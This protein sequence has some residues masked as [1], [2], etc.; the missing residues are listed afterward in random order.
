[1]R[2]IQERTKCDVKGDTME[3]IDLQLTYTTTGKTRASFVW[4][5]I[6]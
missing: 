5:L 6:F 3:G 4:S 2:K 1:M